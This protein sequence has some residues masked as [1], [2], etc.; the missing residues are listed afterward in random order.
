MF[1]KS[2]KG[3]TQRLEE[4]RENGFSHAL[5]ALKA[6]VAISQQ[7]G[8]VSPRASGLHSIPRFRSRDSIS[9]LLPSFRPRVSPR[10][11]SETS[12]VRRPTTAKTKA[13]TVPRIPQDIVDEILDHL[14]TDS[15]FRSLQACALVSK[16]WVQPCRR[17][18]F[19][20]VLITFGLMKNWFRAFPVLEESP[21]CH[22]KDLHICIGGCDRAPEKFFEYYT[23][24]FTGVQAMC[25]YV[26]RNPLPL[27]VPSLW[28]LPQSVTSLTIDTDVVTLVEVR[29]IIAQLPNL[30]DLS[31]SGFPIPVKRGELVG[32]GTILRGRFGG[33]LILRGGCANWDVA[34]MLLE[35]PPG[36]RFTEM[37]ICCSCNPLPMAV[38]LME[39]SGK[40]LI[41]L[42]YVVTLHCKSHLFSSRW[43]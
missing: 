21:A 43:F 15:D 14:A 5:I 25:F 10:M 12:K 30:D 31:L 34:N 4:N 9:A 22:V 39:A 29:D 2:L 28:K 27:L 13:V 11:D 42:S 24:W 35:S 16:P 18:L 6:H 3:M 40:T 33:K 26:S 7:T 23:P 41:K 32:I 20:T 1:L 36:L 38:S 37:R 19:H 17:H 8:F